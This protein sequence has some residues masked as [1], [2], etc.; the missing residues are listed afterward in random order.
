MKLNVAVCIGC[1][2]TDLNA[3]WDDEK[4]APCHW[5]VVDRDAGLGVCSACPEVVNAWNDGDRALRVPAVPQPDGAHECEYE[6]GDGRCRR[7]AELAGR[8]FAQAKN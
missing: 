7:C 5:L 1:G 8:I 4:G 3:C 6:N 2:C